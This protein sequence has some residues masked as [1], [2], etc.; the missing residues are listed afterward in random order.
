MPHHIMQYHSNLYLINNVG[1]IIVF[2]AKTVC[3]SGKI[4]HSYQFF[5]VKTDVQTSQGTVVSR[6]GQSL[7]RLCA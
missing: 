2:L 5:K 6:T 3:I 7:K 1:D 4:I